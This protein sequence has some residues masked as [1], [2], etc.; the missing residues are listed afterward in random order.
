MGARQFRK[1][2]QAQATESG[3]HDL[4]HTEMRSHVK[5]GV[6]CVLGSATHSAGYTQKLRHQLADLA[7]PDDADILI[8]NLSQR[9]AL[10]ESLGPVVGLDKLARG[11][12]SRDAYLED[13]GHRGPQEFELSEPR[14]AEDPAWLDQEL[15]RL[16]RSPVDVGALV[17]RQQQAYEVAWQ[18]LQS[19]TSRAAKSLGR[20]LAESARRARSRERARSAY[21]RDRWAIRLWALRAGELTGLEDQVFY[22][23]LDELL[24]LLS[25]E[26]SA[27]DAIEPR[28]EAYQQYKRLWPLMADY[29]RDLS[30]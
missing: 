23:S 10:L 21:V 22:L 25:G 3:L 11:E 29:V 17:D 24:A 8:A 19:Q 30:A 6:W 15:A 2:I 12:I 1:A 18:R 14:P 26:R 16:Q 28:M 4:W 9:D 7:G 20:K 13:Y 27:T 5:T